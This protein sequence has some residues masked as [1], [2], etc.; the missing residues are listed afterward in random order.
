MKTT[1]KEKQ[2]QDQDQDKNMNVP[3]GEIQAGYVYIASGSHGP[4][5]LKLENN[6]AVLL[7]FCRYGIDWF[8]MALGFKNEP[9]YKILG[10]LT[11][12]IVEE[13]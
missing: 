6:E 13:Q 10:K 3:F 8:S 4:V 2:D 11:E 1:V 9:A 7:S 5:A 12:I